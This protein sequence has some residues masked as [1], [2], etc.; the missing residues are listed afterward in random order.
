MQASW[1]NSDL[2]LGLGHRVEVQLN[3]GERQGEN[4]RCA[5]F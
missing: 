2:N 3:L 4:G 1:K 5:P